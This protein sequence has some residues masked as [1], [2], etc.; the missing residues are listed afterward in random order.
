MWNEN[1]EL[2]ADNLSGI[3]SIVILPQIHSYSFLLNAHYNP[4][5]FKLWW[6]KESYPLTKYSLQLWYV[7]AKAHKRSKQEPVL[8]KSYF[9]WRLLKANNSNKKLLD[10]DDYIQWKEWKYSDIS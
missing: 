10:I 3:L 9:I 7:S 2:K 4:R 6:K 5:N 1:Y 8:P